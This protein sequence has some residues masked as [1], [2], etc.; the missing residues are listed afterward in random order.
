MKKIIKQIVK[1]ILPKKLVNFISEKR[2]LNNTLNFQK[3]GPLNKGK[4][5][6]I[7]NVM[8]IHWGI[9]STWL[10]TLPRIQF[11]LENKL[12]PVIDFSQLKELPTLIIDKEDLNKINAWEL[13]FSQPNKGYNIQTVL[14]SNKVSFYDQ[15]HPI[16]Y[17]HFS[18]ENLN[19]DLP[20]SDLDYKV[21]KNI[22]NKSPL[23][24]EIVD[25]AKNIQDCL[26]P[27]SGKI[28]GVSFRR[29]FEKL[30]YYNSKLTPNGTHIVR[31]TLKQ[32]L[33][34]TY[35]VLERLDYDYFFFTTDD[36]ESLE[37]MKEKFGNKCLY[38]ERRLCHHFV[39]NKPVP[40]DR[41]DIVTQEFTPREHDV[42]LRNKEYLA[43]IYLLSQCDS[44]LS[45]GGTADLFA[46]IIN[47]GKYEH[48]VQP[49]NEQK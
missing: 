26:F 17:E 43:D 2:G 22:Y 25:Y 27:K 5:F 28:L 41:P 7:I 21:F 45:C 31:M 19:G 49:G 20:L 29:T 36:R 39:D 12:I 10:C 3:L 11:A 32:L 37:E 48:V 33:L 14:K 8:D 34:K 42:Y 1:Q 16:S 44:L 9:L 18:K 24:K 15:C 4:K 38:V 6:Y 30:H 40:L 23:S 47:D 13:Y 46:Y 35:E